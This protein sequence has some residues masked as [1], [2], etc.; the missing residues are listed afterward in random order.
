V[1]AGFFGF[2]SR[3][4]IVCVCVTLRE[5][6]FRDV[7]ANQRELGKQGNPRHTLEISDRLLWKCSILNER[8]VSKRAINTPIGVISSTNSL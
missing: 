8:R 6:I 4:K 2:A 1:A 5:L 3:V 7:N